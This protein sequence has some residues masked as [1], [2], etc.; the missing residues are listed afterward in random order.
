MNGFVHDGS[1]LRQ[2]ADF[3]RLATLHEWKRLADAIERQVMRDNPVGRETAAVQERERRLEVTL[4]L[5]VTTAHL[6]FL[7][8]NVVHIEGCNRVRLWQSRE[9]GHAAS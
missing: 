3:Q 6:E 2:N 1:I 9:E 4:L 7:V 8:M 5:G